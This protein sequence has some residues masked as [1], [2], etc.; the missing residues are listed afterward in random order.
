[1]ADGDEKA[2]TP[3]ELAAEA[4]RAEQRLAD[5]ERADRDD[6]TAARF[7]K[8]HSNDDQQMADS[9]YGF[10]AGAGRPGG[11]PTAVGDDGGFD[12]RFLRQAYR[13]S[14]RS[15]AQAARERANWARKAIAY[16]LTLAGAGMALAGVAGA[17]N[18]PAAGPQSSV[19][20]AVTATAG[21]SGVANKPP[22][23][24]PIK[25][26]LI[27]TN[28]FYNVDATDPE[29]DKL[30]YTWT[31]SNPCGTFTFQDGTAV[32]GHPHPPCPN[33]EFHP[34]TITVTVNDGKGNTIT[35][36]Y[37]GGSQSGTGAAPTATPFPTTTTRGGSTASAAPTTAAPTSSPATGGGTGGP[38]VPLV[39]GGLLVAGAGGALI[40]QE[41]RKKR[42]C[43]D[44]KAAEERTARDLERAMDAYD[45][46]NQTRNAT[47][48]AD[49][50]ARD[51]DRAAAAAARGVATGGVS[52][53]PL[54]FIGKGAQAAQAAADAAQTAH[55]EAGWKH[56]D[57]D[58]KGGQAA[59]QRAKDALDAAT[60][61]HDAAARALA[62][63]LEEIAPPPPPPPT[64]TDGG[65][66]GTTTGGT[67]AGTTGGQ[68]TQT[69]CVKGTK[70]NEASRTETMEMDELSTAKVL[71]DSMYPGTEWI[72]TESL[73]DWVEFFKQGFFKGKNIKS[74]IDGPVEGT[75]DVVDFPDFLTYYDKMGD[76]VIK[77]LRRMIHVS[78]DKHRIGTYQL[79]FRRRYYTMT[80]TTWEECDG[81]D[82]VHQR[83]F[84]VTLD[85]AASRNGSQIDV[86]VGS[87]VEGALTRL[88]NELKLH[89]QREEAKAKRFQEGCV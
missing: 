73:M 74:F 15:D 52:G 69:R 75:L 79:E 68:S 13:Q 44:E 59:W 70:R 36:T 4:D 86:Q 9:L 64:T 84:T 37:D 57:F 67:V 81:N 23:V 26:N 20:P 88:F 56:R 30:T 42:T 76:E 80:C 17:G 39:A 29:G 46:I 83:S 41:R 61:A 1:M 8:E 11:D 63:C 72:D 78:E 22:V 77:G 66:G 2:K 32:W 53:E 89:N 65:A 3:D 31:K 85:R 40:T 50:R 82:F 21:P 55:D 45:D 6:D 60:R 71:L 24:G 28:T 35:R 49:Q 5:A 18:A 62:A 54:H 7:A 87:E 10:L 58:A 19:P 51:A 43:D 34:G 33:E 12:D 25:A 48:H 14:Q 38:N 47:T 16:G 27:P